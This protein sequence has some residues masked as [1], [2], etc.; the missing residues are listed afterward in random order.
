MLKR[1]LNFKKKSFLNTEE[2]QLLKEAIE[3]AEK[4]C[5]G[6]IRVF[7]EPKCSASST[8]EQAQKH[9]DELKMSQTALRNGILI[10]I[11]YQEK[12]IAIY[13]DKGIHQKLGETHWQKC[14]DDIILHFKKE[15]FLNGLIT[16]IQACG[17][18]LAHHFPYQKDTDTNELDNDIII[19]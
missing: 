17:Q 18:A 13:G 4:S 6:E 10:Y 16:T 8:L 12:K 11:A 2:V 19:K 5:S 1:L 9:F 15:H 7:L 3:T 14:I